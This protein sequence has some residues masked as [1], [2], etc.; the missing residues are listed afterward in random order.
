MIKLAARTASAVALTVA[1]LALTATAAGAH[2]AEVTA[3]A[4]CSGVVSFTDAAWEGQGA[5]GSV[6]REQSRTNPTIEV[7]WGTGGEAG[8]FTVLPQ[9]P[10]YRFGADNGY[11]FADSF[12]PGA[13]AGS[14]VTVRVRALAPWANGAVD[15]QS[16]Y[17]TATIPAP[18][19]VPTVAVVCPS[20]VVFG[21]AATYTATPTGDGPFT[22]QWTLNGAPIAG[23]TSSTVSVTRNNASD[24][25]AVTVKDSHGQ[26]ASASAAC[27]GTY[28]A[29]TVTVT[30]PH[31]LIYGQPATWTAV[32]TTNPSNPVTY[33]WS[34]N[35]SPI[36]GATSSTLTT[37]VSLASDTI[38][39]TVRDSQN[40]AL[41]ATAN[42]ACMGTTPTAT[43]TTNVV[44]QPTPTATPAATPAPSPSPEPTDETIEVEGATDDSGAGP[45][46]ESGVGV[47]GV[48][49]TNDAGA[50]VLAQTGSEV[51]TPMTLAL[52]LLAA[53]VGLLAGPKL[54]ARR[55]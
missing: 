16:R 50:D 7:A 26:S 17:A 21:T 22:Y 18:C 44:T 42:S 38:S 54:A 40:P 33:Q 23:A 27:S 35:G 28:P 8:S 55:K 37:T 41:T 4:N 29:P 5:A 6:E 52:L 11:D 46:A 48:T 34:L 31:G 13:A 12:S 14:V 51:E 30:C 43:P 10:E 24:A 32:A 49:V 39:V 45:E 25:V 53:G 15:T 36:S 2:H 20:S 3:S 19:T 9:K 1:T 47:E